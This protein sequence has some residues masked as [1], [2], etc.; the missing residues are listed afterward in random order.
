MARQKSSQLWFAR[1]K[2]L[3]HHTPFFTLIRG[4]R[5]GLVP[6][7]FLQPANT[8]QASILSS[9]LQGLVRGHVL[10]CAEGR[11]GRVAAGK[12]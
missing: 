11:N 8:D 7:E 2:G 9:A 1:V 10:L 5:L 4:V 6:L 3:P 12:F